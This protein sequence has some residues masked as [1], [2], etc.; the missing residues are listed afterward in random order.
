[1]I[2]LGK[3][4]LFILA[5]FFTMALVEDAIEKIILHKKK[6]GDELHVLY[7][8]GMLFTFDKTLWGLSIAF[9]TGFYL[10]NQF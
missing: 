4:T 1:M 6:D 9:W 5:L 10:I 2:I 7:T 8:S 3:T